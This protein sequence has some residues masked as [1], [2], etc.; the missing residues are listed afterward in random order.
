[1][2]NIARPYLAHQTDEVQPASEH[3]LWVGAQDEKGVYQ[4]PNPTDAF[5]LTARVS[6]NAPRVQHDNEEFHGSRSP[7]AKIAGV[8]PEIPLDCE[9]YLQPASTLSTG[10]TLG[11][12]DNPPQGDAILRQLFGR[13]RL[14]NSQNEVVIGSTISATRDR[15]VITV[16]DS[17]L[18]TVGDLCQYKAATANASTS[19]SADKRVRRIVELNEGGANRLSFA[20]GFPCFPIAGTDKI[21]GVRVY[22]LT[23]QFNAWLC[24]R[25]LEGSIGKQ[26]WDGKANDVEIQFNP[27]EPLKV[28]FALIFL[29]MLRCG[30]DMVRGTGGTNVLADTDLIF[31]VMDAHKQ[32]LAALFDL[33]LVDVDPT[34][35]T[36]DTVLAEE[37]GL[38]ISALDKTS[39]PNTVSVTARGSGTLVE[40]TALKAITGVG[41]EVSETYD[42]TTKRKLKVRIDKKSAI[43]LDARTPVAPVDVAAATAAEVGANLN[44]QLKAAHAKGYGFGIGGRTA[45]TYENVFSDA[46]GKLRATSPMW[47]SNSSI[48]VIDTG[49]ADSAHDELFQDAFL[50]TAAEEIQLH[51]H[52][53]GTTERGVERHGFSTLL[54]WGSYEIGVNTCS[55]K[56]SNNARVLREMK[57]TPRPM[58]IVAGKVRAY[59][60][61]LELFQRSDAAAFFE[62]EQTGTTKPLHIHGVTGGGSSGWDFP[63][64]RILSVETGG[65]DEVTTVTLT[66]GIEGTNENEAQFFTAA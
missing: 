4:E 7:S 14:V 2:P 10:A 12:G 27:E 23:R 3:R 25:V 15:T 57:G 24:G 18:F 26:L 28:K 47:G 9:G 22:S 33:K 56:A 64:A 50:V 31:D 49:G 11:S 39:S 21:Q 42:L 29:Q 30:I 34:S 41:E 66:I 58:T 59:D 51:P 46:S 6:P 32:E 8:Y 16:P 63:A 52:D 53:P 65:D 60:I 35:P 40:A 5:M 61:T 38:E 13:V 36:Y 48:E 62:D 20:P 55:V 19:G 43:V 37:K 45:V 1:M 17:S 44:A 54:T